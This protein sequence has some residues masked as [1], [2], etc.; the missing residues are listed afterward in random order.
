[1][2]AVAPIPLEP[3]VLAY[4]REVFDVANR[5][6]AG[7]LDR[8]PTTH[9]E[10]LD[11]ALIDALAEGRGP[12]ITKSRT[13]VDIDAHFVGGGWHWERWEIADVGVIVNFRRAGQL[14][15]TKVVLLQSKRLYPREAEFTEDLGLTRPGGFG[16]LMVRSLPAT[17]GE[18]LFRFDDS[19]RYRAL[20][21]GD[22]QWRAIANY[23]SEFGLPVHYMLYHPSSMPGES[24]IPVTL[25]VA[26]LTGDVAVG[27]RVLPASRMRSMTAGQARNYAPSYSELTGGGVC[28]GVGLP[29]FMVDEVLGCRAGYITEEGTQSPGLMRVFNQRSAPIAAAIRIDINLPEEG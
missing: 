24:V 2:A 20:Q 14:L 21:V 22:D 7:R 15:R 26:N 23:E 1:M 8:M 18:R 13:V 12:H 28:P 9:E 4:I 27:V 6:V 25:P 11:F 29:A 10:T 5:R 3:D 16:S 19:C 17:L